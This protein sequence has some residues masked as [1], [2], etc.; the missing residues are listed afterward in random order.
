MLGA[1]V[2]NIINLLTCTIRIDQDDFIAKTNV[3]RWGEATACHSS[4]GIRRAPE[5]FVQHLLQQFFCHICDAVNQGWKRM[6][7]GCMDVPSKWCLSKHIEN[8][9]HDRA[10][11]GQHD[12]HGLFRD[13][14]SIQNG[15]CW[16]S[17]AICSMHL[18]S[19]L[20][21]GCLH[22]RRPAEP[23]RNWPPDGWGRHFNLPGTTVDYDHLWSITV[24]IQ[25]Y[26]I[27]VDS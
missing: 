21:P 5:I 23:C 22:L 17:I 19:P 7:K 12:Q 3:G 4:G 26:S 8:P 13:D 14:S 1:E 6:E 10:A 24:I 9:F 16:F 25:S 18:V 15:S 27:G 11:T 20:N 2:I